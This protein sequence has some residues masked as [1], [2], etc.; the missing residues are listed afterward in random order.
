MFGRLGSSDVYVVEDGRL[1]DPM[2]GRTHPHC[3]FECTLETLSLR[4]L[5]LTCVWDTYGGILDPIP[6]WLSL[7]DIDNPTLVRSSCLVI[8]L[9]HRSGSLLNCSRVDN[10]WRG[11]WFR[12]ALSFSLSQVTMYGR[13]WGKLFWQMVCPDICPSFC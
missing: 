10:G 1:E 8:G 7:L 12:V 11:P 3:H 6:T 9:A 4:G 5:N 2:G 13:D